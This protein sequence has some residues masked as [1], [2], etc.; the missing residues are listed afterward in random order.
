MTTAEIAADACINCGEV[1]PF[2]RTVA[3]WGIICRDCDEAMEGV[4]VDVVDEEWLMEVACEDHG[5]VEGPCKYCL[6]G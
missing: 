6:R 4:P 5:V 3:P 1:R 2:T